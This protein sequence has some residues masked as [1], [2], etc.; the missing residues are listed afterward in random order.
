MKEVF[1]HSTKKS[2]QFTRKNTLVHFPEVVDYYDDTQAAS[3]N[4][5][6]K[7]LSQKLHKMIGRS[8]GALG[9]VQTIPDISCAG[10]KT[11]PDRASVHT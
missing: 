10:T 6:V 3:S 11:I 7:R 4:M 9:Y 5:K 1:R 2:L 8:T